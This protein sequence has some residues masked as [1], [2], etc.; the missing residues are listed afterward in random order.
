MRDFEK[1]VFFDVET[2]NGKNDR[3]CSIGFIETDEQRNV[4][5]RKSILVDPE[6]PFADINMSIHGI[7]PV[8]V[9]GKPTFSEVWERELASLFEGSLLVAHNAAFDLSVL[10]KSMA[11]YGIAA[12]PALYTCT[13]NLARAFCPE[14]NN[15]KLPT[16]C[17]YLGLKMGAH[18]NAL[19]DA[20]GCENIFWALVG[21]ELDALDTEYYVWGSHVCGHRSCH[22]VP[23]ERRV[24]RK[25]AAFRELMNLLSEITKDG[26]VSS[27][28]AMEALAY[29]EGQP[30]L[31]DDSS[32]QNVVRILAQ[33][34]SDGDISVEESKEL[35]ALFKSLLVST[36]EHVGVVEFEG[37]NFCLSGNFEHG[38][39]QAIKKMIEDR[40]G[41][42]VESVTKKCSYV[43]VGGCGNENW[44]M[45]SYGSK[46]K[47]AKD[48]QA[49]GLPIVVIGE[50]DLF[51]AF[52]V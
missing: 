29:I 33:S 18:H 20:E 52:G 26:G 46:V 34:L 25:T 3:I 23:S 31:R 12:E 50:E 37:K 14:C 27:D 10:S 39:K 36:D 11:H 21:D 2:P 6:E 49:K 47:K 40:A 28:E 19:D 43:V 42:V 9:K 51:S 13:K 16:V 22:R 30:L 1:I 44:A 4:I 45:G 32:V 15:L 17:H 35:N 8:N 24:S 38:S 48:M 41:C 7:A 5:N